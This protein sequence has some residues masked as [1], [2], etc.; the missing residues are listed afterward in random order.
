MQHAE[1]GSFA[2]PPGGFGPPGAPFEPP[3]AKLDPLAIASMM[4]GVLSMPCC[5]CGFLGAPLAVG[6]LVTGFV[7]L[8]HVRRDPLAWRG[9]GLAI[10]G[11]AA[12]GMGLLLEFLAVFMAFDDALRARYIG[13]FF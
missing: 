9:G 1:P 3:G 10:A 7:A 2:P 13:S 6:A 5:C 8:G 12:G 4:L 11:I